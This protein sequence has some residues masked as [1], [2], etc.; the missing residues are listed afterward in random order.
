MLEKER[1]TGGIEDRRDYYVCCGYNFISD[2]QRKH[3]GK[4]VLEFPF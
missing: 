4:H 2:G 1:E 3:M